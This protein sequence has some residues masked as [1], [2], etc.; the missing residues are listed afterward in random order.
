MAESAA[1]QGLDEDQPDDLAGQLLPLEDENDL[2]AAVR[3]LADHVDDLDADQ[4]A[5]RERRLS[6]A[7]DLQALRERVTALEEQ[8]EQLVGELAT[9]RQRTDLMNAIQ[10]ADRLK[11]DERAAVCAQNLY[12]EA[13]QGRHAD[14]PEPAAASMDWQKAQGALG[15]SVT[16]RQ[17]I[18]DA[19]ERAEEL[20]DEQLGQNQEVVRYIKESRGADRNTRLVVDLREQ[21]PFPLEV[22]GDEV[23]PPEE[24]SR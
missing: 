23:R 14:T 1:D 9:L 13:W 12:N 17:L 11:P 15:G 5:A 2:V 7:E 6:H 24:G 16:S 8:N 10:S 19:L 22:G 18:Y 4:Q 3:T 20:A 21:D